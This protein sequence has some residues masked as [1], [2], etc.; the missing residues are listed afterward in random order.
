MALSP[1][2]LNFVLLYFK[3][4]LLSLT[5]FHPFSFVSVLE[6]TSGVVSQQYCKKL[7]VCHAMCCHN[8]LASISH[9]TVDRPWTYLS[10]SSVTHVHRFVLR[11][12]K[13]SHRNNTHC[14]CRE[15]QTTYASLSLSTVNRSFAALL[16]EE[17]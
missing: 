3:S 9:Q 2:L 11:L 10:F 15:L 13:Y 5:H 1:P 7:Y 8:R 4:P 6:M 14:S 17:Y 12:Y 16:T